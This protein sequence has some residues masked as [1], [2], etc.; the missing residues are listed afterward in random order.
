LRKGEG[1]RRKRGQGNLFSG[2]MADLREGCGEWKKKSN[3]LPAPERGCPWQGTSWEKKKS[4][5]QILQ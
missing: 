3:G 4:P 5:S 1:P 2:E